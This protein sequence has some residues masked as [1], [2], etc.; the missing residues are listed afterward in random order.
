M[1][2]KEKS[3]LHQNERT[4]DSP[5]P[6]CCIRMACGHQHNFTVDLKLHSTCRS[7]FVVVQYM[8]FFARHEALGRER[9]R[10]AQRWRVL[11]RRII[12]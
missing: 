6:R 5:S 11:T 4:D 8:L 3:K 12:I 7:M 9:T 10:A 2:K 1:G